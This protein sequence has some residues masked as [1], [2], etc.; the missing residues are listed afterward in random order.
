MATVNEVTVATDTNYVFGKGDF[1][2]GKMRG[3]FFHKNGTDLLTTAQ[4]SDPKTNLQTAMVAAYS[5]RVFMVGVFDNVENNG[6]GVGY[7][8]RDQFKFKA[9]KGTWD[10][11]CTLNENYAAHLEMASFL[12]GKQGRY[13]VAPIVEVDGGYVV[14]CKETSTGVRGFSIH[15][16]HTLPYEY[17]AT[18]S[19]GKSRLRIAV[20]NIDEISLADHVELTDADN[21]FFE[22][23]D[24]TDGLIGVEQAHIKEIS[25]PSNGVHIFEVH[26][27]GKEENICEQYPTDFMET[28]SIDVVLSDG[29]AVTVTAAAAVSVG[30]TVKRI[31]L[32]LDQTDYT[33][34]DVGYVSIN[35]SATYTNISRYLNSKIITISLV[36]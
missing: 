2:P 8:T 10:M 36:K 28:D 9:D 13:S 15:Q 33:N 29:T 4:L 25:S 7:E 30:G 22:V 1:N 34:G 18:G 14:L 35:Q 32:T 6:E 27:A 3:F 19:V 17:A 12:K 16:A 5:S 21:T 26:G 24:E 11:I 31:Q 20:K 23:F